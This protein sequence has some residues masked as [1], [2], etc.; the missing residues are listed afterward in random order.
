MTIRVVPKGYISPKDLKCPECGTPQIQYVTIHKGTLHCKC[1]HCHHTFA[2]KL[3][4][5]QCM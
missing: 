1:R 2:T 4:R 5:E 3:E